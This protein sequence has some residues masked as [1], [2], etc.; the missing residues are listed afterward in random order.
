MLR[1]TDA[2]LAAY[3]ALQRRQ[4]EAKR[5]ARPVEEHARPKYRNK[6]TEIQGVKFDSK[7]EASRF[8]Q[9]RRMQEAGLIEDL[10]RQVSFEL[11]PAVK[12]P[13]KNRMSPPLR[14]FADFVYVQ[15]GKQI[16][17]D[18]KGQEKVT[19]GFRIKRHLMAVA[20]YQ[21][22]EVRKSATRNA[23]GGKIDPVRPERDRTP[24]VA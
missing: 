8:V 14:Y 15:D 17:E 6:K 12:I 13:G 18:V 2:Q 16:I 7:A 24:K 5:D 19:E 23:A 4:A 10:R 9:L 21:I 11:A 20:G 3:Q 22:V 1:W